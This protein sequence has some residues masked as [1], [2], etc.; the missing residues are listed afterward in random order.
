M[1]KVK[2]NSIYAGPEGAANPG[3]SLECSA[4]LAT[5]LKDGGF[6]A[7]AGKGASKR[8]TATL[9]NGGG[10]GDDPAALAAA[11]EKKRLADEAEAKAKEPEAVKAALELLDGDNDAHWNKKGGK[12]SVEAVREMTG[13]ATLTRKE[14]DAIAPDFVRPEKAPAGSGNGENGDGD[15]RR[16]SAP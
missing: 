3:E 1:P 11:A 2:L 8:E 7:K 6:A 12:P 14:I 13:S 15:S 4:A 9:D 5:Q 16:S 10:S